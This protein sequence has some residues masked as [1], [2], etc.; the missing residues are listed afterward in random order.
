MQIETVLVIMHFTIFQVEDP[1]EQA[2]KFLQ[3]LRMLASDKIDTHLM[4]FEIYFR[5]GTLR[6]LLVEVLNYRP[7][8][9]LL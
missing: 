4:A 2:I 9:C 8:H 5:K 7:I 3:P 1:L 6:F